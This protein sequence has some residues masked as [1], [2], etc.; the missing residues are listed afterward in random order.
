MVVWLSVLS[1]GRALAQNDLLRLISV[2]GFTQL[3]AMVRLE[4]S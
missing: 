2:R 1:A 4:G 3:K